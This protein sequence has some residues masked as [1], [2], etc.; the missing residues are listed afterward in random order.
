MKKLFNKIVLKI[1]SAVAQVK[2]ALTVSRTVLASKRA[3][4]FVDSGVFCVED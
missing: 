4:G 2:A 3:E 1:K